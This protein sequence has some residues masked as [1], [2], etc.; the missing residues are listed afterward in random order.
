MVSGLD[1]GCFGWWV[2]WKV[3][4][5]AVWR[6]LRAIYHL[7]QGTFAVP[8][9][10]GWQTSSSEV[11]SQWQ[12]I[13]PSLHSP[14]TR[15]GVWAETLILRKLLGWAASP[16]IKPVI[17]LDGTNM[18]HV[19]SNYISENM[20]IF[21]STLQ[22]HVPVCWLLMELWPLS[23]ERSLTYLTSGFIGFSWAIKY[24]HRVEHLL[25]HLSKGTCRKF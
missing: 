18:V 10:L 14:L 3:C 20:L 25:F 6:F 22:L 16:K 2:F 17:N 7:Q 9:E 4:F 5:R 13:F 19:W 21:L 15:R 11:F 8:A 23:C 24:S 12:P 1:G